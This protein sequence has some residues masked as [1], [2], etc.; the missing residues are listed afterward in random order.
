MRKPG[1]VEPVFFY[2]NHTD[3]NHPPG[4]VLIAADSA[5]RP[6]EGYQR[7]YA[8]TLADIDRLEK[9]LQQQEFEQWEREEQANESALASRRQE[10]RDRLYARMTSG[11]TDEWEKEF[12]RNYLLLRD[13]KR[14]KWRNIHMQRSAFLWARHNDTPKDRRVDEETVNLERI[15]L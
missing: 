12:I 10:V 15:N 13:E 3:Q 2:V 5:N 1:C 4:Y 6:M 14:E 8:E 9:R 7:E 11:S